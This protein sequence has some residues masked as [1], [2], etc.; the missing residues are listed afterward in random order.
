[1]TLYD[2][3]YIYN[4]DIKQMESVKLTGD[5]FTDEVTPK[6][7]SMEDDDDDGG[8]AAH[9]IGGELE[10]DGGESFTFEEWEHN[11]A[12]AK[13]R[14]EVWPI[15]CNEAAQR[16]NVGKPQP[17][18][19]PPS[20]ILGMAEVL[21]MGAKKYSPN[22]WMRSL[23]PSKDTENFMKN[24]LSS[25]Y[26]HLLAYQKGEF[27]D[28]ESGLFHLYHVMVNVGFLITYTLAKHPV[29][30]APHSEELDNEA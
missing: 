21:T 13:K 2:T 14:G 19:I 25:L 6:F 9:Y 16:Y 11:E 26:R 17:H 20:W 30:E 15:T 23:P 27:L 22:N 18:L 3:N 5:G 12:L 8:Y 1:M 7:P 10:R 29:L 28:K 4:T 24:T